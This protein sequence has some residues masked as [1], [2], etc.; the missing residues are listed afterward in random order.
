MEGVQEQ[1]TQPE[2]H[3]QRMMYHTRIAS[4]ITRPVNMIDFS[5]ATV[6]KETRRKRTRQGATNSMPY[7]DEWSCLLSFADLLHFSSENRTP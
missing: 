4:S 6:V 7:A 5:T 1:M 2:R 3:C